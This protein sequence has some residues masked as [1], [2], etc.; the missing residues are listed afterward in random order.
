VVGLPPLPVRGIDA[1]DP[2][3]NHR[4]KARRE[5]TTQ[6]VNEPLAA[7]AATVVTDELQFHHLLTARVGSGAGKLVP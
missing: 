7:R 2:H 4:A 3:A 5:Q 1:P 6:E